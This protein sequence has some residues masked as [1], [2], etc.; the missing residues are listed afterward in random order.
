MVDDTMGRA[1]DDVTCRYPR[2][3]EATRRAGPPIL[4]PGMEVAL[5][6]QPHHDA[7]VR[8]EIGH[9]R[10]VRPLGEGLLTGRRP[11][12]PCP[13][14]AYLSLWGALG[15]AVPVNGNGAPPESSTSSPLGFCES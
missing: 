14:G 5:E 3:E 6:Q 8:V 15:R 10:T 1:G 2:S 11:F 4:A 12:D 13:F 9:H 7:T